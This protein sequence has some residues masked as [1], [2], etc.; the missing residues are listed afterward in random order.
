MSQQYLWGD[1]VEQ[2]PGQGV[3][4]G[5][6][7]VVVRLECDAEHVDDEGAWRQVERHAVLPQEGLQLRRLLLQELQR[8]LCTWRRGCVVNVC[9]HVLLCNP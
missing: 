6:G 8:H 9:V 7:V 5:E 2:V 1:D 4:L 3:L